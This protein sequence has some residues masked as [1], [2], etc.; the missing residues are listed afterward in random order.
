MFISILRD[1]KDLKIIELLTVP[2]LLFY[3]IV[4]LRIEMNHYGLMTI[5]GNPL[6]AVNK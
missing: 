5:L 2:F 4:Q 3:W 6:L 1:L